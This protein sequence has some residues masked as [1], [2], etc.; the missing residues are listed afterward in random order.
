MS[1]FEDGQLVFDEAVV[2]PGFSREFEAQEVTVSA[3][4]T[5]VVQVVVNGRELGPLGASGEVVT[6]TFTAENQL[7]NHREAPVLF[8][9][10]SPLAR[11]LPPKTLY[12]SP[13]S[14]LE[15]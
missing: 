2:G 8:L 5:G 1:V 14:P 6:R 11:L 9:S 7:T 4:D 12:L 10:S 13:L 15:R 3:V